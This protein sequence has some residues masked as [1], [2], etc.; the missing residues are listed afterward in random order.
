M[1]LTSVPCKILEH[2]ITSA[3]AHHLETNN[4]L[5]PE[6]HG[7]RKSRSC[8]TQLL[9]LTGELFETVENGQQADIVVLDFA[10]A[11]DKVSHSLLTHKLSS[12]GVRGKVNA[13]IQSFLE[14]RKQAVLV[15]GEKSDMVAVRSGVP[16]GSVIGPLLFL[17]YINDLPQ[18]LKSPARLF[19][20]DTL[21]Y[22]LSASEEDQNALQ[23]D[24]L[25]LEKWEKCWDMEFHPAKC[26]VL[27]A[28]KKRATKAKLY[29][30]HGQT[31]KSVSSAKYLGVTLASDLCWDNHITNI[32]SKANRTLGFLRRN[33]KVGS[34]KLKATAYKTLVRPILE[35][36]STV[37]DPHTQTNVGRLEAV[38]RRAARYT[39][40][41][42]KQ[43]ESV[44][45]MLDNLQWPTLTHRRKVARLSMLKKMTRNEAIVSKKLLIPTTR[46]QR[47][48]E[49]QFQTIH[50]R[51]LYRQ[52][53]F[54]PRTI[55]DWNSLP[56]DTIAADSLDA[57][58][59]RVPL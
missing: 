8:E 7:F 36:A 57:F 20:D 39:L 43:T 11:F 42:Y 29:S 28:T 38:Q 6:Q 4:I 21:V 26:V 32:C 52:Q 12:Y 54:L 1:S 10:K 18:Q 44:S 33:L 34:T 24:L 47:G 30:L 53:S 48:H 5:C 50:C 40:N 59:A 27:H 3:I 25:Q 16:Q 56:P 22:R 17:A 41:R 15:N 51:T 45:A 13:W 2:I 35:Y 23:D 31:L 49:Q 46:Q 14:D 55:K 37:W 19:A 58:K 9:D